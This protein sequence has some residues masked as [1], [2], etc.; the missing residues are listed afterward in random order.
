MIFAICRT[1]PSGLQWVGGSDWITLHR[2]FAHYLVTSDDAMIKSLTNYYFYSVLAPE[3][4]YH[5]ALVNSRF[6]RTFQNDNFRFISWTK[7]RS[8]S[9]DR[10]IDWCGCS[11]YAIGDE[12]F[13][14]LQQVL[15][16]SD[17]VF[18]ARKF[19]AS[20]NLTPINML[21]ENFGHKTGSKPPGQKQF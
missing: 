8:C 2:D 21:A 20:L 1:L 9:C 18:L 12:S 5:T 17:K 7:K 19:D 16:E 11:P 13:K 3:S 15:H 10:P 4:F 14:I 6:C